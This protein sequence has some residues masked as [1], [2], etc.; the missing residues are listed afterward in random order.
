M[1]QDGASLEQKRKGHPSSGECVARSV[2]EQSCG[3]R[4]ADDEWAKQRQRL[5]E[6]VQTLSRWD[7]ERRRAEEFKNI[8][9]EP[10]F[11][12]LAGGDKACNKNGQSGT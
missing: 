12:R 4:L 6:F 5:I 3:R 2:I 8:N 10:E 7:T 11:T 9:S 1:P